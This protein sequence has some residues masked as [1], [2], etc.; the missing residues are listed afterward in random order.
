ME[1]V[2][3]IEQRPLLT[4]IRKEDGTELW[5]R[6]QRIRIVQGRNVLV[7][8]RVRTIAEQRSRLK[9]NE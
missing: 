9:A 7:P 3:V 6:A 4:Q 1:F 8:Q 2:E 5:V